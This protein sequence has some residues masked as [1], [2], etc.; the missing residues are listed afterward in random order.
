VAAGGAA[1][2][3]STSTDRKTKYKEEHILLNPAA[4]A[5]GHIPHQ[6][7][8][9]SPTGIG[10]RGHGWGTRPMA[11]LIACSGRKNSYTDTHTHGADAHRTEVVLSVVPDEP[12]EPSLRK[13]RTHAGS[14]V[15]QETGRADTAVYSEQSKD[16]SPPPP[17]QKQA[18]ARRVAC[19]AV[20]AHYDSF[21]TLPTDSPHCGWAPHPAIL[22][23][24]QRWRLLQ[25]YPL[26]CRGAEE[27]EGAGSGATRATTRLSIKLNMKLYYDFK[28][29]SYSYNI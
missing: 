7:H 24:Q 3:S 29:E 11:V 21:T 26:P 19:A 17:P 10:A 14:G 5:G 2:S 20:W 22:P 9:I 23:L 25:P 27:K 1:A 4:A 15:M 6:Y 12:P 13:W 28:I 18:R 8:M 16:T